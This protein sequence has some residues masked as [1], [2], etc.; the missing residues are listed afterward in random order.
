L[1]S[2]PFL[3]CKTQIKKELIDLK[4]QLYLCSVVMMKS[5][6]LQGSSNN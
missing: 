6:S 1:K 4:N 3:L 2:Y 5:L